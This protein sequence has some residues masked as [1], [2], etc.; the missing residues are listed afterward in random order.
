M[1]G[2]LFL[3]IAYGIVLQRTGYGPHWSLFSSVTV[4]AGSAQF[5]MT[6]LLRT[7]AD[8]LT[9]A[10]TILLINSRH[11]F[12]G[13]TF[14]EKFRGLKTRP[15]LIFALSD[16]T[17]S[18]LC[19]MPD[20]E[21]KSMDFTMFLIALLDQSYWVI[22]SV[23]GG[24]L[25]EALPVDLTGI[26][27]SMTALFTV[28]LVEQLTVVKNR[29]AALIGGVS[30]IVSLVLLGPSTFLLPSLVVTVTLLF[31]LRKPLEKAASMGER[32]EAA[33]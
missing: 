20:L 23:V 19:S 33:K 15:Y 18:L 14:V 25:G 13:L 9:V 21:Q 16:E 2:Y 31:L 27:F 4:F 32:K 1:L 28:I 8:L 3:G 5:V 22:G 7:G 12:Y 11:I 10:V 29:P 26:D 24:I 6:D 17:Y 30:A